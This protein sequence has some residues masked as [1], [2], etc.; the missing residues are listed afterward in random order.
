MA[1]ADRFLTEAVEIEPD[2][3]EILVEL[4][5]VR[6][7]RGL[8]NGSDQAFDRA[9]ELIAPQD[10]GAL[11]SAW[12]RRGRWLRGGVCHPRESRRSYRVALDV[13]D[14][15]QAAD[16]PARA[17]ALAGM[18]WAEAVAGDP[19]RGREAA[20]RDLPDPRRWQPG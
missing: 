16:Q 14:R 9:L 11:I 2:D 15:D 17:E 19:G 5:E 18:A 13:L 7:F 1:E 10:A 3:P 12:L 6:A 20:G 4:A 8:L